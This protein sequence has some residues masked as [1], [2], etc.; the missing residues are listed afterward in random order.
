VSVPFCRARFLAPTT[1]Q[2]RGG[3]LLLYQSS[4]EP[5]IPPRS[6]HNYYNRVLTEMGGERGT[7]NFFRLLMVPEGGDP[8]AASFVRRAEEVSARSFS[9][10]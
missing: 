10:L 8:D 4:Q 7:A 5:A 3:K 2:E 1:D 9:R 6:A